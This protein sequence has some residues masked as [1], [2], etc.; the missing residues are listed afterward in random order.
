MLITHV[1]VDIIAFAGMIFLFNINIIMLNS[2]QKYVIKLGLF[3][4]VS[5]GW[6]VFL[7]ISTDLRLKWWK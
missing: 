3:I 4:C 7:I 2:G 6:S 1:M 5:K